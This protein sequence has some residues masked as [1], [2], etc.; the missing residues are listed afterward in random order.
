MELKNNTILITGGT[1]G[2]GL[3][4]AKRLLK[5]GNTVIVTG[6]DTVKLASAKKDL[7]G[8]HIFQSDVSKPE[9]I[10]ALYE[11]V[12][13][14]FPALNI[15]INNA[16]QMRKISLHDTSIGLSDITREIET[17]LMGLSVWYRHFFHT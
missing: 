1:S 17:N 6:R 10:A 2:F 3:E 14:Q 7:A 13:A 8:I 16:G 4:F 12:T 15:L 11:K 9:E 5:S